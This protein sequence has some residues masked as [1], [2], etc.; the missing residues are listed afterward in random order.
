MSQHKVTK[1]AVISDKITSALPFID[2]I[3]ARSP[4]ILHIAHKNI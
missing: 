1:V 2:P 3:F 4:T